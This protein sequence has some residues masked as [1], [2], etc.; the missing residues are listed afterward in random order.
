MVWVT[1][2][3]SDDA[4][5]VLSINWCV[6]EKSGNIVFRGSSKLEECLFLANLCEVELVIV[7]WLQDFINSKL[8][9][10]LFQVPSLVYLR[11]KPKGI[12]ELHWRLF[13]LRANQTLFRNNL[14]SILKLVQ[15]QQLLKQLRPQPAA[16]WPPS[17]VS[18]FWGANRRGDRRR[19]GRVDRRGFRHWREERHVHRA[20]KGCSR[21]HNPCAVLPGH[22][23][24]NKKEALLKI[25]GSGEKEEEE[26]D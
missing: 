21:S 9:R 19:Q 23:K 10:P 22:E 7:K 3:N 24:M 18:S 11:N 8:C 6:W 20:A 4:G 13:V 17:S 1:C 14:I 15:R 16:W 12:Q 25:Q 2:I 26:E 5:R